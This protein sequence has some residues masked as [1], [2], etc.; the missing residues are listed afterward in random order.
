MVGISCSKAKLWTDLLGLQKLASRIMELFTPTTVVGKSADLLIHQ[1]RRRGDEISWIQLSNKTDI[2]TV[3][4]EDI[5]GN[6]IPLI[7]PGVQL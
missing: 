6:N 1:I 4:H 7:L 2:V 3:M 5:D